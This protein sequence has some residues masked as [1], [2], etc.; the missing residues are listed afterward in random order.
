LI[1]LSLAGS[2]VWSLLAL[3]R[4]PT[5]ADILDTLTFGN[6]ASEQAHSFSDERSE[7]VASGGLGEP[8]RRLLPPAA[9]GWSG[10]RMAFTLAIDPGKPVYATVRFWGS[11]VTE[12]RL[13]L[14]ADG[15]QLGYRHLGDYDILDVGAPQPACPGRFYYVTSP[16]PPALTKGKRD[17][18]FEIRSTGRIWGYGSS[19]E[20]YQKEMTRPTRGIYRIYTHMDGCFDPP[21]DEKQGA[22]PAAPPVRAAPGP[23]VLDQLRDRVRREVK[24]LLDSRRPLNQMQMHLL[25]RAS[26]VEWTPA[27]AS[28]KAVDQVVVGIDA[29]YAAFRQDPKRVRSD[30]ST[31]NPDWFGCG[32]AADA[33]RLMAKALQPALDQPLEPGGALTRRAAWS[34]MFADGRDWLRRHR[35]LYTNQSMIVDLNLYRCNRGLA[36]IDPAQA[37]PEKTVLRYL[38]ES[39][40]LEP[41]LGS[42]TDRGPEK[43]VGERY[44]QT[45]R[46]GLTKELGYVGY[47]GEVLDWVAQIYEVSRDPAIKD[48]LEKIARARGVF[49]YPMLDA[50]GNRA[51][52]LEAVVGWRDD[53][54][55]GDVTYGQRP[56]WDGSAIQVAAATLDPDAVG[57]AQQMFADNQFFASVAGQVAAGGLRVTSGLLDIPD[58]HARVK[59]QPPGPRRLPMSQDQPDLAFTDEE[60]GVVAIK[61]GD[62]IFYASLYWRSRHAI[63]GLARVHHI[64][65][66]FD[67]IAVVRQE[68]DFEPSGLTWTRPDWTDF[69]FGN[70]G[71][72]YPDAPRSAHAGEVLPIAKIPDGI[73]FKPGQESVYA[74]KGSFYTLRYG[75]WLIAMNTGADK[76]R[77]LAWPT[78]LA[79]A[80]D[81]VTRQVMK[82]DAQGGLPVAPLSTVVLRTEGR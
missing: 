70:G 80:Q 7:V 8:A 22:A 51:M 55:P 40:G 15:K 27:S 37:L 36:A 2:I 45:T 34:E 44:F 74:G 29:L 72:R 26:L 5:A 31:W 53:H 63:N 66:L 19:F 61:R 58:Q 49:R 30:P 75:P 79:Q 24:G 14:F 35:R 25:A 71:H 76:S 23:E 59:A 52:R 32:P 13:F 82:P 54:Y 3:P 12:N 69:G 60:D 47:Y 38:H 11:D 77:R 46:R 42:E 56:T 1:R 28:P 33:A 43:P 6:P 67:R 73:A 17:L 64:T 10:G 20:Q 21:A 48:Q 65:P 9:A 39:V 62:E 4:P 41:W 50:E 78:G 18:R 81:L 57:G 68:T 16:L